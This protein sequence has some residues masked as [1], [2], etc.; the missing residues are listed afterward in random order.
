[1]KNIDYKKIA[2]EVI[3]LEIQALKKLKQSLNNNFNKAV[4]AI[5]NCQSKIILCGVGKSGII[6]NKISATLSSIGTPSFALS[7]SDCSHG[8]M[9]SIS[10][11]DILILISY[12]GNSKELK[13]II[14]YA[15][16]N[17]VLLIGITSKKNSD[18]YRN[19]NIKLITPEVKEAGLDIVPTSST[20]NQLSIGDALAIATLK[21][22]KIS[23][24]DFKKFHPSGS[25]GERLKTVE[26]LMLT[27]NKIPF[28]GED[29]LMKKA[30]KI[31]SDKNLGTLIV[32]NK[33][34]ITTGI[35]T[36]G[37]IRRL[38]EKRLNFNSLKVK[39][40]MT[41][42]PIKVEKDTLATKALSIMNDKK[43]TSLCVRSPKNK[44]ITIGILHIHNILDK[45]IY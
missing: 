5:V 14:N 11:K 15:N 28:I 17:K 39:D 3:S 35:I 27:K 10:R 6:A 37:Q 42:N 40:V 7:A 9:G 41:K 20:I 21:K 13:N 1:M 43:I 30:L 32:R 16:R 18:L 4:A 25:L 36:D 33:K 45:N 8:D 26:D 19:S 22:R 31:M 29:I 44:L 24:I 38:N 23:S 2:K 12:S 34:K